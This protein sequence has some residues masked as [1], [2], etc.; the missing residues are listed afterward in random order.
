M[1]AF[2]PF[3]ERTA[4]ASSA[5]GMPILGNPAQFARFLLALL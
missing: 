2:E 5:L 1:I 3:L 4:P